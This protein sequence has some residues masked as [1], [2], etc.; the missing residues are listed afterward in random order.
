MSDAGFGDI[1][2]SK[3]DS[4]G[5]FQWA[6]RIGMSSYDQASSIAVDSNDNV[7]ITG[8][9]S[10]DSTDF[11]PGIGTFYLS[12]PNN[13]ALTF[14]LKLDAN[15]NFVWA[16]VLGPD[17]NSPSS[18]AIDRSGN[19]LITGIF[20][21]TVDFDPNTGV[22]NMSSISEDIYILKLTDAGDFIWSKQINTTTTN[23]R[24]S[25]IAADRADNL[26]LTGLLLG[27]VDFNPGSGIANLTA[28]SIFGAEYIVKLD[29]A[30][31]FIWAKMIDGSLS[32]TGAD[33]SIRVD[34][35][36][37][38]FTA[39]WFNN[40]V[41]FDPNAGV[42]NLSVTLAE[43]SP[44]YLLKLD[45]SGTFVWAKQIAD[46]GNGAFR[47]FALDMSDNLY[48]TGRL[49]TVGDFDPSPAIDTLSTATGG[50]F[51]AK[52]D[53]AGALVWATNY[54]DANPNNDNNVTLNIDDFG[55]I[56]S[57]GVFSNTADFDPGVGVYNQTASTG[58]A[59]LYIQKLNQIGISSVNDFQ[60]TQRDILI[61]PNPNNGTFNIRVK[62]SGLY[63]LYNSSG[64][65]IKTFDAD[66]RNRITIF[67]LPEGLYYISGI[68]RKH[69]SGEIMVIH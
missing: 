8:F 41:D 10:Q 36:G 32:Q 42:Y 17:S 65:L 44:T 14:M 39:G 18:I 43:P 59:D 49:L 34:R 55:N 4:T 66:S 50:T 31:D 61:Y 53:T 26:Y 52:Y 16:K 7:Y 5:N 64:Q 2:I 33:R 21:G 23:T 20:G 37:N 51:I 62:E 67:N 19:L 28:T 58:G 24:S 68:G 30:G 47:A 9:F 60:Q 13:G 69:T 1:F 38:L 35:K 57:M 63:N 56:I 12:N 29:S 6:K 48:V 27:T 45:S 22:E 54:S 40:T 15:G 11:D 3:L 25:S 46:A